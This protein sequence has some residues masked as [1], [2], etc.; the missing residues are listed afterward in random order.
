MNVADSMT[1]HRDVITKPQTHVG[2][3]LRNNLLDF[4]KQFPPFFYVHLNAG[5][6]EKR[7][8]FFVVVMIAIGSR[9]GHNP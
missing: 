3:I 4:A 6:I 7:I 2:H 1:M 9:R 8:E 5:L